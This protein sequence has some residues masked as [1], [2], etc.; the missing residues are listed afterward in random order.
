[1]VSIVFVHGINGG[2]HS[3]WFKCNCMW[4]KD[5]LPHRIPKA[6]IM[7][8]GYDAKFLNTAATASI[9]DIAMTILSDLANIRGKTEVSSQH[10]LNLISY[11]LKTTEF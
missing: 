6:R 4:P 1:M 5:L 2:P 3:T 8:Y 11:S 7:T 9:R 10:I